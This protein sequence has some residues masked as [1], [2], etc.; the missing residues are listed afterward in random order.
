[1]YLNYQMKVKS[2]QI[3]LNTQL[4]FGTPIELEGTMVL[5]YCARKTTASKLVISKYNLGPDLSRLT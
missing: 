4:N 1:M 2:I 3:S 5:T